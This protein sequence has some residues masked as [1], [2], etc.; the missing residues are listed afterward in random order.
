MEQKGYL[1]EHTHITF[2]IDMIDIQAAF[3]EG[4]LPNPVYIEFLLG[5][6]EVGIITEEKSRT[7]CV[8]LT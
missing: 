6:L 2:K 8:E 5:L 7:K 4:K 1:P 3:L